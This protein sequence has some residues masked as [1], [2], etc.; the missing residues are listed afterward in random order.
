MINN[1][2]NKWKII[3]F[4]YLNVYAMCVY[5]ISKYLKYQK[6]YQKITKTMIL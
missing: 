2:T 4:S 1:K 3:A 5:H 6:T